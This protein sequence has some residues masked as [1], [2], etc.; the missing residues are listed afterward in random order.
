V[1]VVDT[2]SGSI[3]TTTRVAGNPAWLVVAL[4]TERVFVNASDTHGVQALDARSGAIAYRAQGGAGDGADAV[5]ETTGHVVTDDSQ[6]VVRLLDARSG[7]VLATHPSGI[8]VLTSSMYNDN[9]DTRRGLLYVAGPPVGKEDTQSPGGSR[10]TGAVLA[11]DT[12]SGRIVR[13]VAVTP[14]PNNIAVDTARGH[15]LTAVIGPI[16]RAGNPLGNGRLEIRNGHTLS[17]VRTIP[18]GVAPYA[19]AVAPR[20]GRAYVVNAAISFDPSAYGSQPT[21]HGRTL[22]NGSVTVLDLARLVS[23]KQEVVT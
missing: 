5:D 13:R 9:L 20:L 10:V 16:D 17:L 23:R 2:R 6:G 19:L 18:V 11:V 3:V 22:T 8:D 1:S 14:H 12:H 7:A 21:V 4:R 15:V